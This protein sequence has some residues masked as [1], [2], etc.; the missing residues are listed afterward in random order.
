MRYDL[1]RPDGLEV[2]YITDT[3]EFRWEINEFYENR[4]ELERY[5]KNSAQYEMVVAG[6]EMDK[7]DVTPPEERVPINDQ[8]RLVRVASELPRDFA[9]QVEKGDDMDKDSIAQELTNLVGKERVY[10]E[11]PQDVPEGVEVQQGPQGGYFYE[12]EAGA[13]DGPQ[14]EA[15]DEDGPSADQL[16]QEIGLDGMDQIQ[17]VMA[18]GIEEGTDLDELATTLDGELSDRYINRVLGDVE[19]AVSTEVDGYE[20][21]VK[22]AYSWDDDFEFPE[23]AEQKFMDSVDEETGRMA[24]ESLET[25]PLDFFSEDMAPLWK[26]VMDETGNTNLL[27]EEEQVTETDVSEEEMNA[28]RAHKEHVEETLREIHGDTITVY[29]GVYGDAGS[30]LQ[31]AAE[32]GEEVEWERRAVE[33]YTTEL[34]YAKSYAQNPGGVVVEEEIPVEDVWASSHTGFLDANENELV[35]QN[36]EVEAISPDNIHTPETLDD[37]AWNI[38]EVGEQVREFRQ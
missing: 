35:V 28:I 27:K 37:G 9:I 4:L 26:T 18:R 29:R 30:K 38:K 3:P 34:T 36:D 11:S 7:H 6:G 31:E 2:G 33:S 8:G 22:M 10:V 24:K 23:E 1:L 5:L 20:N 17:E 13:S 25:W 21:P 14:E 19:G 15:T 12:E 32:A 16:V